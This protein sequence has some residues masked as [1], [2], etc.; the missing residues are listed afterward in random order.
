VRELFGLWWRVRFWRVFVFSTWYLCG[1][2]VVNCVVNVVEKQSLLWWLKDG[3]RSLDLIFADRRSARRGENDREDFALGSVLLGGWVL[4]ERR[5]GDFHGQVPAMWA[6][7]AL[8]RD[9][10]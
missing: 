1:Q 5:T 7:D 8:L 9:E 6:A 2:N 3:T 4:L 10:K